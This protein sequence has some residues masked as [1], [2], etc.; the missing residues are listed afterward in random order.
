MKTKIL[1]LLYW[2]LPTLN[3]YFLNIPWRL[4]RC[5]CE[6][7][8][9][10]YFIFYNFVPL[11]SNVYCGKFEKLTNRRRGPPAPLPHKTHTHTKHSETFTVSILVV[12]FF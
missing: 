11:G 5:P 8:I 9:F 6:N 2:N 4:A 3:H 12:L 7:G 1:P 10:T